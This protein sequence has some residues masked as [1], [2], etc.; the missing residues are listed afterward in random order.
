MGG[1][2][3]RKGENKS[4]NS[5]PLPELRP[6]PLIKSCP[7]TLLVYSESQSQLQ[8]GEGENRASFAAS[9]MGHQR[10][11]NLSPFLPPVTGWQCLLSEMAPGTAI[12]MAHYCS[13]I[14]LCSGKAL[15]ETGYH[16]CGWN[17]LSCVIKI[18]PL[19]EF[20]LWAIG[21]SSISGAPGHRFDPRPSTVG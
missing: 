5:L 6:L 21:I 4:V 20:P 13:F 7:H 15:V 12:W 17:P 10:S 14:S 8:P 11:L 2:K 16:S 3:L 1:R 9:P 18:E 19:T